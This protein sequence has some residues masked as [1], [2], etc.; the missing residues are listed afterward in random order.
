MSCEITVTDVYGVV[1]TDGNLL[2]IVVRGTATECESVRVWVWKADDERLIG[3][4]SV[5]VDGSDVWTFTFEASAYP[6]PFGAYWPFGVACGD[7]LYIRV[8]CEDDPDC[9][10]E[11]TIELECRDAAT[12]PTATW[13][14]SVSSCNEDGQ[15]TVTVSCALLSTAGEDITAQLTVDGTAIGAS[16]TG[17]GS[18]TLNHTGDYSAGSYTFGV[19]LSQPS[20]CP[21][22]EQVVV[23]ESCEC[24][25]FDLTYD[26]GDCNEDGTRT[27]YVRATR[28]NAGN[29]C[30]VEW[31]WGDGTGTGSSAALEE[32]E[33]HSE[34][35]DYEPGSYTVTLTIVYPDGCED[36]GLSIEVPSCDGGGG[37]TGD[38]GDD[39][40][41]PTDGGDT[42]SGGTDGTDTVEDGDT[43]GC[44]PG[45]FCNL[46][47][48]IW[49]GL[50][51][52]LLIAAIWV[53]PIPVVGAIYAAAVAAVFIAGSIAIVL[54]CDWCTWAK[55]TLVGVATAV[56]VLLALLGAHLL[57]WLVIKTTLDAI[58]FSAGTGGG[59]GLGAL[60]GLKKC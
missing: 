16:S 36:R 37:G 3:Y 43:D 2:S 27:V 38:D 8:E 25:E 5:V 32:G 13:S 31:E 1:D 34:S 51:A 60:L 58:A 22:S 41:G 7:S 28:T 30:F 42:S 45:C 18:L 9:L 39:D 21:G 33:T 6:D 20:G 40:G 14:Q 49:A 44:G 50:V 35:H 17:A 24:P 59:L 56:A 29:V 10:L 52:A 11:L 19:S 26:V 12:C 23:V 53:I 57:G 46:I 4:P 54:W 15:R 48:P 55:W 47:G